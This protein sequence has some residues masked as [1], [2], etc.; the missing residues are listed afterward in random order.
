MAEHPYT[1]DRLQVAAPLAPLPSDALA[2]AQRAGLLVGG[3]GLV[4]GVAGRLLGVP[5][6][7]F[8]RSY[9]IGFMF[10][11]GISL[12]SMAVAMIH[13]LTGGGWGMVA[14][15]PL[16]AAARTLPLLTLY[17]IPIAV[18]GMAPLYLWARPE[19][20][21]NDPV[22][23]LKS[24]YLNVP[25]FLGRAAFYFLVWNVLA[26]TMSRWSREQ[27]QLGLRPV[28]AERKF[29]LL[30]AGGL[31]AY[32]LT[33]TFASIDWVM[34]LDPHWFSTIF[35]ILFMGGQ[36]LAALAFVII[37]LASVSDVPPFAG[38]IKPLHF[39]DLGKLMFAF[40]M[41]W[42]Y[43]S[44]SQFL[45]IWSGNLPEEIP[46]YLE[47]MHGVWGAIAIA[48]VLVQFAAPFLLLLS[49][50]LKRNARMLRTVALVVLGMRFF[51]LLWL[52]KPG[53]E[54]LS[55]HWM[56]VVL[57]VGLFGLWFF[58]FVGQLRARPALPV[59][60]PYFA[61]AMAVNGGH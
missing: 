21:A 19:V 46:W 35:G 50:E 58:V 30:S 11:L 3:A 54:G 23:Q 29:R 4:V 10:C 61:E 38:A 55:L 7:Q 9:L 32:A 8:F 34:S 16:E 60:D 36:G 52:I 31:L 13:H 20:V 17:F 15:R 28:G 57:P 44:F 59:Y 39:H 40:V 1:T 18:F 45:I 47:R 22:L 49:R 14:R 26:L 42:A 33:I 6:E 53:A 37:V 5:A 51:D 25:F 27:D 41:L 48:L 43:F 56:D 24:F 12:G 2:G